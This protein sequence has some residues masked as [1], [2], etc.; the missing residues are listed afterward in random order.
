MYGILVPFE[1]E[2]VWVVQVENG[3]L[4][5]ILFEKIDEAED[6]AKRYSNRAI[7]EE[8]QA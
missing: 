6:F 5:P 7:V 1:D 2:H 8:Y 4:K 3:E